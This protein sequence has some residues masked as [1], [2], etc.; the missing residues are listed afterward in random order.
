MCIRDRIQTERNASSG[1]VGLS[2]ST[3][4]D[5]S[6]EGSGTYTQRMKIDKTGNVGIGNNNP[7]YLFSVFTNAMSVAAEFGRN[8]DASQRTMMLFRSNSQGANVGSITVSNSSTSFN[9]GSDYR[10]KENVVDITDGITRVKQLE[11]KKFNFI[12]D[13]DTTVDGFLAHEAQA[14]VPESVTGT[15]DEVDEDGNPVMQGIDQA[16]LV[17]LLTAALQEAIAKIE[18]L[19]TKVEALEA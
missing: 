18:V 6:A 7:A 19:E 9:T 8:T 14:V 12:A 17:P 11:P 15:K 13:A 5:N 4:A 3:T 1:G 10:L 16:K 2:F